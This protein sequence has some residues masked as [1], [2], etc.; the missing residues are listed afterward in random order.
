M[1]IPKRSV[2]SPSD[3]QADTKIPAIKAISNGDNADA[4]R[5]MK[6][7][8]EVREG[9]RGNP[10][11]ALASW[12]DLIAAGLIK[13]NMG[14]GQLGGEAIGG[15]P[16]LPTGDGS[17]D[18]SPPPAPT[19]V[20][21]TGAFATIILTWDDPAFTNFSYAEVWRS[22]TT[23]FG[24]AVLVGTTQASIYADAIGTGKSAYYWVR[25]VSKAGVYG[26][27]QATE[28]VHGETSL[29]PA[30]ALQVLTGSITESQLYSALSSRIN[31]I[32]GAA[33]LPSSVNQRIGVEASKRTDL[34]V[35]LI[36][37]YTGT[38]LN[39]LTTGLLFQEASARSTQDA[40][41]AQRISLLAAGVA[42]GF[43]TATV[44]YFD[45]NAAGWVADGTATVAA[46]NGWITV[47]S[48]GTTPAI[49]QSSDFTLN[50]GQYTLVKARIRRVAGSGWSGTLKYKTA[51]HGFSSSY[52][53]S[54]AN[55]GLTAGQDAIIEF[56]MY[57]LTAGGTDW[58]NSTIKNLQLQ[59][60]A[61]SA[62]IFEID[63]IATGRNAPGAS[64]AALTD[65]ATARATADGA[66]ATS[67]Q[68]LSSKVL[69]VVDPTSLNQ[70]SELSSGL[71]WQERQTRADAVSA[72]NTRID[73]LTATV[74]TNTATLNAS[75]LSE[76]STRAT[77]DAALSSNISSVSAVANAKN[78]VFRSATQ[79]TAD[80]V[81]D[82]WLDSSNGN[83]PKRWN[84]TSWEAVDD[85]RFADLQNQL[86]TTNAAIVTEQN[87]RASG[88]SAN[89]TQITTLSATV[90]SNYNALNAAIS[91]EA[92]AR[93]S[94]VTTL[95]AA[96]QSEATARANADT[97]IGQRI[98]TVQASVDSNYAA[99]QTEQTTRASADNS[100]FAQYT[101]KVDVNGYVSGFGL[102]STL[103]N[104]TPTSDF[105]IRADRFSI[106]SPGFNKVVPFVV[107]ATATTINGVFVPAGVYM[108]AAYIQN[109]T[110][111]NAKI[112][113]A[114][115][116]EAKISD[117]AVS[118]AKIADA[119][120][121]NVKIANAAIGTA[122]IANAAISNAKI[123]DAS[124]TTA[125][126]GD[127]QI[128]N[129]KIASVIQSNTYVAG[130]AG[131]KIDKNGD[132]EVNNG[133][134]RGNIQVKSAASGARLEMTNNVIKV[135][136][137]SGRLRVKIG[138][139]NA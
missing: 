50:G 45:N 110:V 68:L 39:E 85:A 88:D 118:T 9:R 23:S 12:R 100:L 19:N 105:Q 69:G 47:T 81:G 74:N 132:L 44:W 134:F 28:G 48:T 62:D 10:L 61:T 36:G 63:W 90:T 16:F 87:A 2:L 77:Q 18:L 40:N 84:G 94:N 139:L 101:V 32:D 83:R 124:I 3:L 131:W 102:A 121:T 14:N 82:L 115:I 65:E 57:T 26:P 95:N 125:K 46:N 27:Y 123:A 52:Y 35:Q 17:L 30:Y 106:A 11:D 104:G 5:Q 130:Q 111:T 7:L 67:R 114:A 138:D 6:E 15:I 20:V 64:V 97:A 66:E 122:Q 4:L 98:D 78:K 99:I 41:L 60:G 96:I 112:G 129:A 128:T 34:Q 86:N 91:N 55:P 8:L 113:V 13:V 58:R 126:I 1:P 53:K 70:L 136:D 103:N 76:A 59:L 22:N 119:A 109:G 37:G 116:D 29:D 42:G 56:D 51:S 75:I 21:A 24:G 108:D 93:Q 137:E 120:I 80:A 133:T 73:G 31:L 71:L 92:S 79:P 107:Q 33:T 43:D 54:I 25:Y 38:N 117:L 135:F 89:A 127:A 72:A 49:T